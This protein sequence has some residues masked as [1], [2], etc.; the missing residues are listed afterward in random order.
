M[1]AQGGAGSDPTPVDLRMRFSRF[2]YALKALRP[3][4]F[5]GASVRFAGQGGSFKTGVTKEARRLGPETPL[6]SML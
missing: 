4:P 6:K 1:Q 2:G 3:V 5:L